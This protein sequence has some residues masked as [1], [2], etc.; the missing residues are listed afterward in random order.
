MLYYAPLPSP[1]LH[2]LQSRCAP[3]S[4]WCAA[5]LHAIG[6]TT[7]L[8]AMWSCQWLARGGKGW[9]IYF[10]CHVLAV[11]YRVSQQNDNVVLL[12]FSLPAYALFARSISFLISVHSLV[13]VCAFKCTLLLSTANIS[14]CYETAFI[15][16]H[17]STLDLYWCLG[18]TC[19]TMHPLPS[20]W[21][22][23]LQSR[24]APDPDRCAAQLHAI[25]LT[26]CLEEMWSCQW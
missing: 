3:D 16:V 7:C 1:W 13:C 11:D 5:Q 14:V 12:A 20:P 9:V 6:L 18:A 25:G 17:L 4:V 23:T 8:G 24:C 15:C 21:L 22:H 2:T 10:Q 19:F 26:T